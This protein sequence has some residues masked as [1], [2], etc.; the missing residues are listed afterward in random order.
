MCALL[1]YKSELHLLSIAEEESLLAYHQ[2]PIAS[3]PIYPQIKQFLQSFNLL[4]VHQIIGMTIND[5][6]QKFN[7]E[8]DVADYLFNQLDLYIPPDSSIIYPFLPQDCF[9]QSIEILQ[10][11]PTI[12][13][14]LESKDI[15]NLAQAAVLNITIPDGFALRKAFS[16]HVYYY[17]RTYV[18]LNDPPE[19]K[20][21]F[22]SALSLH[23]TLINESAPGQQPIAIPIPL[24]TLTHDDVVSL[25]INQGLLPQHLKS[26]DYH[27]HHLAHY[28]KQLW[29][30]PLDTFEMFD[31]QALNHFKIFTLGDLMDAIF[32]NNLKWLQQENKTNRLLPPPSLQLTPILLSIRQNQP[33]NQNSYFFKRN[34]LKAI[35]WYR[36]I[37][38]LPRS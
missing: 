14:F 36:S 32:S 19:V 9:Q 15:K 7:V 38:K 3:I 16:R 18:S 20:I 2:M 4:K 17:R 34:Y 26:K 35:Q 21:E 25:L 27:T 31:A 37:L 28:L 6:C 5:F 33:D 12:K 11:T 1:N 24:P 13:Q 30:N 22:N 10:L 23:N 29:K 8:E